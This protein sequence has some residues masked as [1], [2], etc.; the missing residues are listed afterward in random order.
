[1]ELFQFGV[2]QRLSVDGS[3]AETLDGLGLDMASLQPTIDFEYELAQSSTSFYRHQVYEEAVRQRYH[4]GRE[5]K[6]RALS[7]WK[8]DIERLYN[9]IFGTELTA[10]VTP[11]TPDVMQ[12]A[13]EVTTML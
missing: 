9:E 12:M 1:M 4:L 11:M 8:H 10:E 2:F 7:V 5:A 3:D 13:P 6:S